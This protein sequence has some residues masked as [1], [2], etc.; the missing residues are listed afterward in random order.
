MRPAV[1]LANLV[2]GAAY[3]GIGGL[4]VYDL[5]RGLPVRGFSRFGAAMAAIAFTCGPHH[6]AHGFHVG[7]EGHAASALDLVTVL[8]GLPFGVVFAALRIEAQLGG[9]GDRFVSG[10]PRFMKAL[11]GLSLLYLAGISFVVA[12]LVD[13]ALH[14]SWSLAPQ[15]MLVGV[16]S[17]IGYVLLRTQLHNHWS[18]GGWSASGGAMTG[19][20]FT[21]AAMHLALLALAAAGQPVLDIHETMIDLAG[22]PAGLYFLSVV[23]ALYHGAIADWNASLADEDVYELSGTGGPR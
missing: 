2:L 10:T 9:P 6:V 11:P 19:I 4:I 1:A 8:V 16:Y 23:R 14:L 21:C 13:G 7:F 3:L 15:A 5:V 12:R 20:F 17:A 22:V 18:L